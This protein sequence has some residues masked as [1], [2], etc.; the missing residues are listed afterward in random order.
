MWPRIRRV[1]RS[2]AGFFISV[3]EDPE[4]ILEQNIRD[5]EEQVPK[6]N[7]SIAMVRANVTLLEKENAKYRAEH[8]ELK[9]KMMAAIQAGRDDIAATYAIQLEQVKKALARNDGQLEAARAAYEKALAVKKTFM[10]EKDRRTREALEAIRAHKRAQWQSKVAD[11]LEGFDL[12]G[13][14]S[15]HDEMIRRIE[16]KTALNEARMEVALESSEHA[17]LQI[18]ESAERI[19]AEEL[20][21]QMKLEMG[22]AEDDRTLEGGT[23]GAL[24]PARTETEA[25]TESTESVTESAEE[26]AAPQKTVGQTE[27]GEG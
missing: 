20:V 16:E 24:G 5:L 1:F 6:L 25:T 19:R 14:D 23:A 8:A 15:T 26:A 10:R 4:L 3:A 21:K 12:R 18:E 17:H 22:L 2:F 9:S 11:A 27:A 13:V 7:E